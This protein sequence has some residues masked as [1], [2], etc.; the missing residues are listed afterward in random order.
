MDKTKVLDSIIGSE[1]MM[2]KSSKKIQVDRIFVATN[3]I[4]FVREKTNGKCD[5]ESKLYINRI[6][7]CNCQ[8]LIVIGK[9]QQ[10]ERFRS[11]Y[12]DQGA[13]H[14]MGAANCCTYTPKI[15][16]PKGISIKQ[17]R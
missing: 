4:I 6:R 8:Y 3:Q 1:G 10:N 16:K 15:P 7:S 5:F 2:S 14:R 12:P 13:H 9:P 11:H 17:K